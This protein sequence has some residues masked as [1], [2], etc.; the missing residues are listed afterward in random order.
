M[1]DFAALPPEVNSALMY[2]GPGSGPMLA[3]AAAWDVLATEMYSAA[4]TYGSVISDL[5]AAWLGPSSVAM[6]AAAAPFVSWIS[7]TAAVAGMPRGRVECLG[8]VGVRTRRP[9][10]EMASAF[11]QIERDVGQASVQRTAVVRRHVG[12][13]NRG[14]ERVR[15]APGWWRPRRCQR[16]RPPRLRRATRAPAGD[17]EFFASAEQL[18]SSS[19][20]LLG[21]S[22]SVLGAA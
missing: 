20:R 9:Q 7:A 17:A 13:S 19:S 12:V 4:S 14:N 18:R 5:V 1:L 16:P 10:R 2:T 21:R 22:A 15:D 8:N 6:A 3:A 11:L